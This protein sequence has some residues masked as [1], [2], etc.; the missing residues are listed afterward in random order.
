MTASLSARAVSFLCRVALLA[1]MLT[2]IAG[3]LGMRIITAS[4]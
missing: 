2:I 4:S 3:I 1:E